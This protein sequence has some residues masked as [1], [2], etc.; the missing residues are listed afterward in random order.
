MKLN[1]I[2]GYTPGKERE[3]IATGF[4]ELDRK[5]GGLR[6]GHIC[7]IGA[8]PG[9]GR[10][11]FA[12]SLLRNIGVINK[13]PSAFFS[14]EYDEMEFVDKLKASLIGRRDDKRTDN[15]SF[16]EVKKTLEQI[17]FT[18]SGFNGQHEVQHALQMMKEAPV[19]IEHDA[20]ITLN[21]LI[22][23]MERLRQ[24]NNVRVVFI[25]SWQWIGFE[26]NYVEQ[27]QALLKLYGAAQRLKVAVVLTT[28]LDLMV[29][30]RPGTKRPQLCDLSSKEWRYTDI[31]S[32]LV[33]FVYRPEYYR[34]ESFEDGT[35]SKDLAEIMVEKNRFGGGGNVR[36]HFDN[37][38]SFRE[39]DNENVY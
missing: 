14:L 33:M 6:I 18:D 10:T 2:T 38:V 23:R 13:V 28:N 21:E 9:V 26:G 25:D 37:H 30:Y 12:V 8:R 16:Y 5:T 19:W 34:F 27:S 29:E 32:A 24:E 39:L 11:T 15:Q 7:T 31:F 35:P 17:G 22:S 20:G 1:R 4:R 36:M 3:P